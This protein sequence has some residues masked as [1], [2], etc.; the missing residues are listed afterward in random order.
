MVQFKTSSGLIWGNKRRNSCKMALLEA[1]AIAGFFEEPVLLGVLRFSLSMLL[2]V[3]FGVCF[4]D[5]RILL[6]VALIVLLGVALI[7][8]LGVAL[9]VLLGVAL[10]GVAFNNC[11]LLGVCLILLGVRFANCALLGVLETS[12]VGGLTKMSLTAHSSLFPAKM[13]SKLAG[14]MN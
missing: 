5:N 10:L 11:T 7:V 6:G 2:I 9:I 1:A 3:L 8:L 14:W 13:N 4:T 12:I